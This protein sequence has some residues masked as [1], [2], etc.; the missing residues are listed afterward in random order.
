MTEGQ[1]VHTV[2]VEPS[3]AVI[4]AL[5]GETIIEA[6]HRSGYSWPS[7]C[8]GE[9]SCRTCFVTVLHGADALSAVD[10]LEQRGLDDLY[11]SPRNSGI[12]RLACQARPLGNVSVRRRGVRP[13]SIDAVLIERVSSDPLPFH[14]SPPEE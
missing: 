4:N 1:T 2:R 7:I 10:S 12:L 13:V 5:A 3:G 14:P 6:A 11:R 8:G 9:G